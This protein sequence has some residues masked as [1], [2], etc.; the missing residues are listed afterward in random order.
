MKNIKI[1]IIFLTFCLILATCSAC[2]KNDTNGKTDKNSVDNNVEQPE[3]DQSS[4]TSI[5]TAREQEIIPDYLPDADYEGYEFNVLAFDS[6]NPDYA[7]WISYDIYTEA[8]TGEPI[9]DAVYKRNRYVEDKYNCQIKETKNTDYNNILKKVVKSGEDIY[10]VFYSLFNDITAVASSGYFYDLM[11]L[12]NI[13]LSKPWWNQNAKESLSI[14]NILFF[15]PC[16]LSVTQNNT[17]SSIVFNKTLIKDYNMEYPYQIVKDGKWTIDK[18]ISMAKDVSK[19]LNG[20]GVMDEND[21]YGYGCYRDSSLSLMHGAGGRIAAKGANGLPELTLNS[22]TAINALNKAFDLM[23]APSGF[24]IHKE[25]SGKYNDYYPVAERMFIEN[26]ML[27]YW[28]LLHDIEQFRNMDSD[29]G[30][31]PIPK[32]SEEQKEYGCTVNQYTSH[33]IAVPVTVQNIDRTT[34]ILEAL[35][36]KSRYTLLPAYY[37]ISMQRKFTRDEESADMLDIIL[38]SQVYDIGA[39]YNIGGYSWDIIWMTMSQNRNIVSLYEKKE[40]T[41]LKDIDKIIEKYQ[42]IA[43]Q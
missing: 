24:N 19:D 10:D 5:G 6:I 13:D 35:T 23:Y 39:I 18:L 17:T 42:E 9:N 25:L 30:I 40:K 14:A 31:V 4:D 26:Q 34:V 7:T 2:S 41:A 15:S 36:A 33:A 8:E 1:I 32:Y 21:L 22:E 38:N 11:T 16:D 28:I 27:F 37:D 3:T 12:P 43:E 20:D 29:F